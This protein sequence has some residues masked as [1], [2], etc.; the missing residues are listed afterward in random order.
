MDI[1]VD[2]NIL[3][4]SIEKLFFGTI[5]KLLYLVIGTLFYWHSLSC[6]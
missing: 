4:D 2:K 6:K 5:L 1:L 3:K